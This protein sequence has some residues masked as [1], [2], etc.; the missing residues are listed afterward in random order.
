MGNMKIDFHALA[1]SLI[2]RKWLSNDLC[3]EG[4]SVLLSKFD[5]AETTLL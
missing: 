5:V 2:D 4:T 1:E 3:D